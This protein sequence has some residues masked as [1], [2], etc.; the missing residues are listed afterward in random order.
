MACAGTRAKADPFANPAFP[1]LRLG[2]SGMTVRCGGA[3][4]NSDLC[5]RS[6][7][8]MRCVKHCDRSW[9]DEKHA[10]LGLSY[11]NGT[12]NGTTFCLQE[13]E[14]SL[15]MAKRIG[16]EPNTGGG[17][18]EGLKSSKREPI[19]IL[20]AYETTRGPAGDG[21]AAAEPW[22]SFQEFAS[23]ANGLSR[24]TASSSSPK[25]RGIWTSGNSA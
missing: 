21:Q 1:S 24:H 17:W 5:C 2:T 23:R 18:C 16:F 7:L 19:E 15:H 8:S 14:P 12:G 25:E 10:V 22:R 4:R 3:Y 6:Y 13:T 20:E 9:H 11:V